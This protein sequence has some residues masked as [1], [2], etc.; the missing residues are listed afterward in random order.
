MPEEFFFGF[1]SPICIHFR[2]GLDHKLFRPPPKPYLYGSAL[3]LHP[4]RKLNHVLKRKAA[5]IGVQRQL[6]RVVAKGRQTNGQP[7]NLGG[8][9]LEQLLGRGD[10][11]WLVDLHLDVQARVYETPPA[12]PKQTV[13]RV[14]LL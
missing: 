8:V 13:R 10:T 6:D 14:D 5:L 4:S 2:E 12:S 7:R 3:G 1:L 9:E 11:R